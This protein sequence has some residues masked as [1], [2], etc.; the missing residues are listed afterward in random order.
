MNKISKKIVSLVTMAAFV[1]TLV[2]AA[3]FA[4]GEDTDISASSYSVD[5][6]TAGQL[7]VTL[8]LNQTGGG[9]D[10]TAFDDTLVQVKVSNLGDATVS[11]GASDVETLANTGVTP[12]ATSAY[13]FSNV[14]AG[15]HDV[16]VLVKVATDDEFEAIKELGTGETTPYTAY[17]S[18]AASVKA[19]QIVLVDQ[20]EDKSITVDPEDE[21][22]TAQFDVFD[23]TGDTVSK[24]PLSNGTSSWTYVWATDEDGQFSDGLTFGGDAVQTTQNGTA[25]KYVYEVNGGAVSDDQDFTIDFVRPGTYKVYAGVSS[26]DANTNAINGTDANTAFDKQIEIVGTPITVTVNAYKYDVETFTLSG[27]VTGGAVTPVAGKTNEYTWNISNDGISP[28]GTVDY[29]V[30]GV[31]TQE[32]GTPAKYVNLNLD[33]NK[34]GLT[35]EKDQISTDK[36]GAFEFKFNVTKSDIYKIDVTEEG[37]DKTSAELTVTKQTVAPKEINV[38]E[39]GG[40]MLAGTDSEYVDAVYTTGANNLTDAVQFEIIDNNGNEITE[41]A[42][43]AGTYNIKLTAPEDSNLEAGD[44]S[45]A[46]DPN[47][48]VYTLAYNN[49]GQIADD[50]IAG[51]YTVTIA[52]N[53]STKAATATFTLAEFGEVTDMVIDVDNANNQVTLSTAAETQYVSGAVKYVD[54]QGIKVPADNS[55]LITAEGA[56]LSD[57]TNDETAPKFKFP[58]A[59]YSI[60]NEAYYGTTITLKVY[61]DSLPSYKTAEV[62][63]V[64]ATTDYSLAFDSTNGPANENNKVQVTVVDKDGNINKDVDAADMYA[65]VVSSSNADAKV[66]LTPSDVNNGKGTLT[67]YSDKETTLDIAVVIHDG[68]AIYSGNL[69]YTVGA[70]ETDADETT[71]VMTMGNTSYVVNN[72]FVS[73]DAAPY[74]DENWRTM[75]PVRVLNETFGGTVTYEDNVITIENGDTTVV[76]TIGEETYTVNDEEKTM[77]TAPVI[78]DNDRAY[79]PVRFMAEALGYTVTPLQAADGTTASVVFQK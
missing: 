70:E 78:R 63:V 45:L 44:L 21:A 39:D 2:P 33:V 51:E 77:N 58:V 25:N 60:D 46:W 55:V 62:T 40:I 5:V 41:D 28:N 61:D 9:S 10:A 68:E 15:N 16:Q 6:S 19:S 59:Q 54:E 8:D 17:V 65:Y 20:D 71:V 7:K 35:F 29:V 4:A 49:Q 38:I 13:T 14:P 11:G 23:A 66:D 31:A 42:I 30:S 32:D 69:D 24:L 76:M 75:V 37:N 56:A 48:E 36:D 12:T 18:S 52:F 34:S 73:G 53:N 43:A 22:V 50:L 57:K 1:L 64:A 72:A 74:V 26:K 67:I 27:N 47:K 3:A 79:V